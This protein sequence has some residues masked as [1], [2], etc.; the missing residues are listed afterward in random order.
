MSTMLEYEGEKDAIIYNTSDWHVGSKSF[1]EEAALKLVD[2]VIEDDA[3]I[4]FVGDSLEGKPVKSKHFDPKSLHS[5]LITIDA[6]VDYFAELVSPIANNFLAI[7]CGNHELY[8]L[9]DVNVT[10]M[11]CDK[12]DRPDIYADY[13]HW[14]K[15]GDITMHCWHGRR[16]MPKGAKD[17]I[18]REANRKAWLKREFEDLAGSAH[19]HYMGHTHA[20]MIVEPQQMVGLLN[21]GDNVQRT[22]FVAPE[23]LIDGRPWVPRE[24]RWY[25]NTG[26]LRQ[27]G[28][29]QHM[30]YAEIAGYA[31]MDIACT[32]TTIKDGKISNIEKVLL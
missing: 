16:S 5:H 1:N 7:G 20:C 11:I 4:N 29:F 17:P 21:G 22:R 3:Y 32:K 19:A 30:D 2:M 24:S 26:T 15:F 8:L 27:S 31:P 23:V 13:Q 18:Q 12:L 10:Q 6:Q 28:S 9:P 14:I 25:V